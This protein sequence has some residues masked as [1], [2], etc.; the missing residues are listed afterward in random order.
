MQ[1]GGGHNAIIKTKYKNDPEFQWNIVS[2]HDFKELP[3]SHKPGHD[4]DSGE[5][6]DRDIRGHDEEEEEDEDD[7]D[8]EKEE[9]EEKENEEEKSDDEEKEDD[10]EKSDDETSEKDEEDDAAAHAQTEKKSSKH[11]VK[12][13]LNDLE[14]TLNEKVKPEEEP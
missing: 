11:K 12:K 14:K 6:G 13:G 8:E 1:L 9:G 4:E 3:K 5:R 10:E 7:D 2:C